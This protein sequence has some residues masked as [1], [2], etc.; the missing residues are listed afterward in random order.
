[1]NTFNVEYTMAPTENEY[2]RIAK[3]AEADLNTYQ[4][5]TG[6]ARPQ[7]LDD[8]GVN[9]YTEKKFPS[10]DVKYGDDLSTNRG[11]NRRIPPEEGGDLDDR[12]R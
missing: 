9:S 8:A 2:T 1:M 3:N 5:K 12:G 4:S 10:S 6:E 7:S 11:Y